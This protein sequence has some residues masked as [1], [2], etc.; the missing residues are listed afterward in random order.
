VFSID[1][2]HTLRT[3]EIDKIVTFF[4]PRA[5]VLEIGAGTGHQALDLFGRGIDVTAI[6]MPSSNYAQARVFSI[7]EYDGRHIPFDDASFDI[8][9]SSNVMEHVPDLHQINREIRRVLRPNGYCVHVMPTHTWRLWTTLSAFPTA[10]QNAGTLK[11]QLLPLRSLAGACYRFA[12]HLAAPFFQPRHGAREAGTLKSQLLP[13]R[14]LAG[15][16]LR[17]AR[18]LAAPF[19]Q[20][21]HGARGNIISELW[22]F[23]PNWWRRAFREDGFEIIRDEPMGLFYTGN[24]TFGPGLSLA[25]RETLAKVIGSACHLFELRPAQQILQPLQVAPPGDELAETKAAHGT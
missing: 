11:Y 9:F 19:F 1:H 7:I 8:I 15:A 14:S 20:P 10:F 18:H 2:L 13:F 12:R 23:H 4:R 5:R 25:R 24:M 17:L 6:D 3:A 21:R 16:W 22:L